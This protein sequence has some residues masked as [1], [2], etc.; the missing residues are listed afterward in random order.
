M[1]QLLEFFKWMFPIR[2]RFHQWRSGE[3]AMEREEWERFIRSCHYTVWDG[4]RTEVKWL[5][6]NPV[7]WLRGWIKDLT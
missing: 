5:V 4:M 6:R 7:E 2:Y 1:K 3:F